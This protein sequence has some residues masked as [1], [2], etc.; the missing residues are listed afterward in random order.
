M[1]SV[2]YA[3]TK[4]DYINYY[5]YVMW[6][7]PEKK[8]SKLKFYLRQVGI[9]GLVIAVLFYTDIFQYNKL[10]LYIYL[11][12]LI[13][14]TTL[15]I[16]SARA[17]VKKQAEKIAAATNNQSIFLETHADISEAGIT[18]KDELTETK[19]QWRAFVRKQENADYYF[20]FSNSIQ[21]IIFPKRIFKTIEEKAQFQKLLSEHLS[22]DAEVGHLLKD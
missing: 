22:F 16:F 1:I 7:A 14:T 6:D 4:E 3:L 17:N 9:N 8:K 18:I 12:I 21:A 20:L 10:Y 11:G 15:Q 13:I 19:F 2:K 5:T